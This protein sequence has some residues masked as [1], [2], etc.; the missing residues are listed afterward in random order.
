M[1]PALSVD[2]VVRRAMPAQLAD[3]AGRP[4]IA[5]E[6]GE[7]I[8][9]VGGVTDIAFRTRRTTKTGVVEH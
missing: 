6:A 9:V 3:A 5:V 8:F 2:S 4:P 7:A 1:G